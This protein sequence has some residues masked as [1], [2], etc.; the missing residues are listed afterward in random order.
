MKK[1]LEKIAL[2]GAELVGLDV[3]TNYERTNEL[4][5]ELLRLGLSFVGMSNTS[6]GRKRQLFLVTITDESAVLDLAR[7][8]GQKA[9][10]ISDENRNTDVVSTKST[11][12][13]NLGKLSP[14]SKDV[15]MKSKF[16]L[17]VTENGKDYFWV[18]K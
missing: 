4:R 12:R 15:A 18:T 2:V 3:H 9:V 8:F 17:S 1:M 5:K 6:K 11:G 13:T 10:L 7:K 14:V 16:Y